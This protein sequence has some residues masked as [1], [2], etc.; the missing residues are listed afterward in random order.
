MLTQFMPANP[1]STT[2]LV[3][4]L[5]LSAIVGPIAAVTFS[6]GD[7]PDTS[8]RYMGREI[9]TTMHYSGAEWLTRD[10]RQE[11]EDCKRLLEELH[12]KPGQVI[13]DM[14]CGNGFYTLKLADLAGDKGKVY[15][16]DIQQGMLDMLKRRAKA[17][18]LT[19][20][21]PLLS[22]ETNPRLK[23]NSI[24]LVLMVDV[25]HEFSRPGAMLKA[26][27]KSLKPDGRIALGEF[28]AEDPNVPI[29]PEHKM[30]KKQILREFTANGLKLSGQ[31]DKLP[32]QHLMF[33]TRDD[34]PGSSRETNESPNKD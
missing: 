12:V 29:K 11:E 1:R 15:A 25:Y 10:S 8:G 13:C 7:P 22:T 3:L 32:W 26:I 19:N 23:E 2:R 17:A 24:D 31:F 30:S 5:L 33:F 34:A 18:K 4:S 14:G 6:Y 20:I 21:V 16:V 9:A 27:R 28:R